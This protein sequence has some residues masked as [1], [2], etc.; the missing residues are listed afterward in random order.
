MRK[1]NI[2]VNGQPYNVTV[3]ELGADAVLTP[4]PVAVPAPAPAPVAPAAPA[5]AA[6]AAPAPAPTPAPVPTGGTR[7]NAPMPGNI[8][9]VKVQVGATVKTGDKLVVLEAMKMENDITSPSNGTITA[10]GVNKGDMVSTGDML[11]VIG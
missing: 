3:E 1:F 7:V 8:L 11:V 5:P 2:T 4:A 9:D 6:A 10:V